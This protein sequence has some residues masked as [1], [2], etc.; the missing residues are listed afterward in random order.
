M[1]ASLVLTAALQAALLVVPETDYSAAYQK[2]VDTGRP[3]VVLL[4][5]DWCPACMTMKNS[6]IPAVTQQG[7]LKEVEFTYVDVDRQSKLANLLS[8][9]QAIPQLIRFERKPTGWVSGMLLGAQTPE[10]VTS[11]VKGKTPELS[12]AATPQAPANDQPPI[13]AR[14]LSSPGMVAN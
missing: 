11:F 6:V 4:G 9:A 12:P 5:A 7:G 14:N 2:S 13:V 1:M 8:R 3:L 10:Q